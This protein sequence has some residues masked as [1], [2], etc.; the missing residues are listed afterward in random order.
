MRLYHQSARNFVPLYR[1]QRTL[2]YITKKLIR[3]QSAN[4]ILAVIRRAKRADF[5]ER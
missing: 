3:D 1:R 5:D 2:L 4:N